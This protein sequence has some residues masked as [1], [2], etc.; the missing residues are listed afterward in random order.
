MSDSSTTGVVS[1]V[2][3]LEFFHILILSF[4]LFFFVKNDILSDVGKHASS[5]VKR[6]CLYMYYFMGLRTSLL[7]KYFNKSQKTISTWLST[8]ECGGSLDRKETEAT[9]KKLERKRER[10]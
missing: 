9:Y 5:S 8:F 7:A 6:Y 1:R 3:F 2:S 4:Q 10:G